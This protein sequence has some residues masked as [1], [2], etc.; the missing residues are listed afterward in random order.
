MT[1]SS[2]SALQGIDPTQAFSIFFNQFDST[3]WPGELGFFFL[4]DKATSSIVFSDAP[5]P[6]V[7]QENIPAN[8]LQPGKQ[9][10][11]ALFF[12]TNTGGTNSQLQVNSETQ[13]LFTT[14]EARRRFRSRGVWGC[15]CWDSVRSSRV[16]DAPELRN[17][18]PK[19][20]RAP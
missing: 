13:G 1:S 12:T 6:T 19:Y 16:K 7:T 2:Y 9:Y 3:N 5:Q 20:W 10:L 8:T 4:V 15:A 17:G 18:A 14:P 11:F